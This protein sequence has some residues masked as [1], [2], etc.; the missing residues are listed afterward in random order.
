MK[1]FLYGLQQCPL[2]VYGPIFTV[3]AAKSTFQN[4]NRSNYNE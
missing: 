4:D 1:I 2:L 3:S